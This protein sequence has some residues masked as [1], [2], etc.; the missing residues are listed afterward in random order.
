MKDIEV[1]NVNQMLIWGEGLVNSYK[2]RLCNILNRN[3]D[4]EV[5]SFNTRVFS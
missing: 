1:R 4:Y 5:S 2:I 3:K